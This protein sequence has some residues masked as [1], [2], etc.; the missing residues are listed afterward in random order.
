MI[1]TRAQKPEYGGSVFAELIKPISTA[2]AKVHDIKEQGGG[3]PL[4]DHLASVENGITA[5]GWISVVCLL[6]Y[7]NEILSEYEGKE[8]PERKKCFSW[9][10]ISEG[11][12]ILDSHRIGARIV[13]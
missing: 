2:V 13:A 12:V 5:F 6:E 11:M 10:E 7:M 8:A 4:Q 9:S 3:T 1:A